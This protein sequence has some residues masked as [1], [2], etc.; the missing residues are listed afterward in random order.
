MI[1]TAGRLRAG[2]QSG[3]VSVTPDTGTPFTLGTGVTYYR[4]STAVVFPIPFASVPRIQLT[5][6]ST[7]PGVVIEVTYSDITETG[8]TALLARTTGTS[9][10][11]DWEATEQI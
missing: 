9:T 11:I 4:G 8:F 6:R 1:I 2:R 5:A 3:T 10:T 7:T